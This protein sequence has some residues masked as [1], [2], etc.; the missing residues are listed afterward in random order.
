MVGI[1]R[2]RVTWSG[3]IGAPGYTNL[4]FRDFDSTEAPGDSPTVAQ[5]EDACERTQTFFTAIRAAFPGIVRLKVEPVV[6]ILESSTGELI[7]SLST[8][9]LPEILG[10]GAGNYSAAAGGVV[11]WRTGGIRNGRRIRGRTFLVP[12]SASALGTNGQLAPA[13]VAYIAAAAATLIDRA[14]TPDLGVWAR[15]TGPGLSDG[16]WTVVTGA[17]V[18][19]SGAILRSRRD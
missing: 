13:T 15:P 12:M 18:P 17:Q 11:S 5:A 6:D 19:A 3:F 7:D 14:G 4:F 10:G 2:V 16:V 9:A 1:A 8:P